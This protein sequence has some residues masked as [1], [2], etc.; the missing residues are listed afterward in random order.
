METLILSEA[1][2]RAVVH[3]VGLDALMDETIEALHDACLAYDPERFRIPRRD[4]F[5]YSIPLPGLLEWMPALETGHGAT[6][7]LVGYHPANPER[8]A[9]P[10]IL[11]VAL[12]FEVGSGHLRA[13]TDATFPTAV[14]TG[15][16]SALATRVLAG[17]GRP[18]LGLIGCGAQAVTQLHAL[19]R[20]LD[21]DE[22]LVY[23][24]EPAVA[25]SLAARVAP[26]G[27]GGLRFR[28]LDEQSVASRA[29][30]LCTAT[31]VAPGA[32]PV[33]ADRDL[34]PQLHVNAV[35]SDFPGKTELPASL[36]RRALVCPDYAEQALAEGECQQLDAGALGPD[37]VSL[38][39]E[40]AAARAA[41]DGPSVFDSTGWALE[42]HVVVQILVAHAERLGRGTPMR[43]ESVG[44]DPRDPYGFASAAT[45]APLRRAR[46]GV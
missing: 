29:Q 34:H 38:V 17:A 3:D 41:L 27:L 4:G 9:L 14:R 20:V 10:T 11:S 25:A 42:D 2:V 24:S 18:V 16:A 22:V 5:D 33:F 36:V 12:T 23:D 28:Q 21:L 37:L 40:P 15:A 46:G 8:H 13:V 7:K 32:G 30:V 35:G 31:S 19:S 26:L 1:D 45:G 6:V 39:K 43:I 44:A